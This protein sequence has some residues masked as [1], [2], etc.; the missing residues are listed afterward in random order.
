MKLNQGFIFTLML[1]FS[2]T[3][4]I[5]GAVEAISFNATPSENSIY[6]N[7]SHSGEYQAFLNEEWKFNSSEEEVIFSEL[8][9]DTMYKT[10]LE[11]NGESYSVMIRTKEPH[12]AGIS[13]TVLILFLI[14]IVVLILG[15]AYIPLLIIIDVI[16]LIILV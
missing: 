2:M 13:V 3:Y 10:R 6:L 12:Y 16:P 7:V 14:W 15:L 5:V 8:E 9:T 1:I 4:G 11:E